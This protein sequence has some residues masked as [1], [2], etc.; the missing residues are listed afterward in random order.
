[1]NNLI[2]LEEM[3]DIR[4]KRAEN[5]LVQRVYNTNALPKFYKEMRIIERLYHSL[6]YDF[7]YECKINDLLLKH[8][9]NNYLNPRPPSAA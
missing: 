4:I 8:L 3:I 9:E 7:K 1:M 2:L 6:G 5:F